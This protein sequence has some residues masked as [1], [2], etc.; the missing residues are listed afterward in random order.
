[1]A[2][3]QGC[4]AEYA[5]RYFQGDIPTVPV[6]IS[7]RLK[8]TLA[9]ARHLRENGRPAEVVVSGKHIMLHGWG[10]VHATLKHEMIHIWQCAHGLKPGHGA[11]FKALAGMVGVEPAAS[12][13]VAPLKMRR[14]RRNS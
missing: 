14:K 3:L 11:D 6:R 10:Q 13:Y 7:W 5:Q 4:Y 2:K 1:M 8:R 12:E 9:Y